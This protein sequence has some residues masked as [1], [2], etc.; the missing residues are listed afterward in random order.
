MARP[1]KVAVVESLSTVFQGAR[2][3]VLNDFTGLNVEKLSALRKLCREHRV[4]YRV[5]K[6]TLAKRGAQGTPVEELARYF[7]GPTAI[8]ASME[9]ENIPAKILAQFAGEN[10]APR[11]KAALV[12]GRLLDE[13]QIIELAKLPNKEVLLSMALAGIKAPANN[14][15]GVLQG[16]LRKLLYAMNAIVEKGTT[17]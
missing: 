8:A 2:S 16:T 15:V 11:F 5:V 9:S 10:E 4:D 3:V 13:R 17:E 1:E 6:N 14:L 7:D 12:E